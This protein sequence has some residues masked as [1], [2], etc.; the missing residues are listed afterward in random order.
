VNPLLNAILEQYHLPIYGTHG[1]SHWARVLENGRRMAEIN[2]ANLEVIYL[3]ALFHD[4][5]RQN[6]GI[7]PGHGQRGAE[8]AAQL[9]RRHID[10]PDPAFDLLLTACTL[11]TRGLT[12]GD[13]TVQTCWDADRLDLN[14]VGIRPNPDRL[15]TQEGKQPAMMDWAN[16]RA[17][18]RFVPALIQLE[19]GLNP[20]D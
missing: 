14:R 10:L 12:A 1:V 19:W 17:Q 9:R 5:R 4:A 15:C 2:G 13:V 3:F 7:D 18:T 20:S 11:H 8:L 16:E 6:E